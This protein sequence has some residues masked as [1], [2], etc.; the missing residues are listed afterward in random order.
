MGKENPNLLPEHILTKDY[1]ANRRDPIRAYPVNRHVL[2]KDYPDNNPDD[3]IKV[4]LN[5]PEER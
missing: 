2:T 5:L 1:P 3:R 4:Y